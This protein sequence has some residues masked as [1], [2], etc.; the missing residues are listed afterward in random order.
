MGVL[1]QALRAALQAR[2]GSRRDGRARFNAWRLER[3]YRTLPDYGTYPDHIEPI[4]LT[5]LNTGLRRGELFGLQWGVVDLTAQRLTVRG[6]SAKTG[7][8]RHVPLNRE[9]VEV[10]RAWRTCTPD[11][12]DAYVFPGPQGERMTTLKTAWLKVAKAA[13]LKDFT[14]HDLRHT[15]ASKLVMAG[16][17]LNT[18]RE[19]LGHSDIKMTLRYAH[20]APEHKAA[21]VA[22]LVGEA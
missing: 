8:T 21:A 2:D 5:A 17:D 3:K 16:V 7:V 19:L 14:F 12:E 18:V 11:A 1:L 6:A 22:K 4:T 20:L 10:L 13:K 15:F 9:V